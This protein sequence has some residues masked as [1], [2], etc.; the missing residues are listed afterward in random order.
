MKI[1]LIICDFV[2]DEFKAH[3]EYS[4]MMTA[5]FPKDKCDVYKAFEG[6][7]PEDIDKYDAFVVN[8]SSHSVN[9]D[10]PWIDALKKFVREL[11][12]AEKT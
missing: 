2:K 4:D 10:L 12:I 11:R 5:L 3:G 9:E 6:S 7:L 8:G 1:A